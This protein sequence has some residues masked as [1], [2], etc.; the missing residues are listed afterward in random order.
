M[1]IW[2]TSD[3]HIGHNG[4][5]KYRSQFTTNK[6]HDD[7]LFS[8]HL[9]MVGKRDIT[10]FQGDMVGTPE[11]LERFKS[12]KGRK[13]L[14]L[15]NHDNYISVKDFLLVFDDIVGPIKKYGF[16]LSHHPIHPQELYGRKNIHGHTHNQSV[17]RGFDYDDRYINVCPDLHDFKP[18][19]LKDI[20][21]E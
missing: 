5:I 6:E 15:G 17:M 9:K 3:W 18:V 21:G 4:I 16:W 19:S 1:N 7:L 8:N 11:G 2:H 14:L 20:K 10:Y 13:F 12:L